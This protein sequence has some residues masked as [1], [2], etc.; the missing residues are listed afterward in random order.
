M[1][2]KAKDHLS[3]ACV[4]LESFVEWGS[5]RRNKKETFLQFRFFYS[6]KRLTGEKI[7]MAENITDP[8]YLGKGIKKKKKYKV[9]CQI[10]RIF[11]FVFDEGDNDISNFIL[12]DKLLFN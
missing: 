11:N 8:I 6:V 2:Q 10:N 7:H 3:S 4:W 1:S 12:P 9:T 5:C